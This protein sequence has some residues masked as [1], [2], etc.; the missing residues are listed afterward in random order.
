MKNINRLIKI[1]VICL[2]A[3]ILCRANDSVREKLHD[4][5]SV[6]GILTSSSSFSGCTGF[7]FTAHALQCAVPQNSVSANSLR[8]SYQSQRQNTHKTTRTGFTMIKA[9]KSMNES[10]TLLFL[11]SIVNYPSGMSEDTH[12][13]ISLGKLII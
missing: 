2:A 1:M 13:L 9:G 3:V 10:S 4:E 8:T 12:R 5:E 6:S 11:K 7:S